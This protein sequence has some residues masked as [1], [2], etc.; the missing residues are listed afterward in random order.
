MKPQLKE[1]MTYT[2]DVISIQEAQDSFNKRG[3]SG[4]KVWC[5]ALKILVKGFEDHEPLDAQICG[6]TPTLGGIFEVNDTIK[7][8]ITRF[9]PEKTSTIKFAQVAQTALS[10]TIWTPGKE[11]FSDDVRPSQ[12]Q[13]GSKPMIVSGTIPYQALYVAA[14]RF[15]YIPH[16]DNK[17]FFE[18]V[19]QCEEYLTK[20]LNQ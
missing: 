17:D 4:G 9:V 2:G 1:M 18:F 3:G 14:V 19:R 6:E 5:H 13:V 16:S 8:Q 7:F 11:W 10:K 20:A 15:Q 12:E